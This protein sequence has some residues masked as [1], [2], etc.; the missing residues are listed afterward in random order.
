MHDEIGIMSGHFQPARA[1]ANQSAGDLESLARQLGSPA[2]LHAAQLSAASRAPAARDA[3]GLTEF[4]GWYR[5]GMLATVEL[6][7]IQKAFFHASRFEVRELVEFD[8]VLAN[9]AGFQEFA[10]ASQAVGRGQLRRLLPLRDQRFVRRYYEAVEAGRARGWHTL[11]YGLFLSIYSL[12]LRQGMIGYA[13]QTMSG[14]VESA[15]PRVGL[16]APAA[17]LLLE[18]A[19]APLPALV[20]E[21]LCQGSPVPGPFLLC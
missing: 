3:R 13:R 15:A 6:P 2:G 7:A 14:F 8:G 1:M 17:N 21:V 11:V 18:A 5:S 19:C 4:L 10:A 9:Q 20:E 16:D 12:P